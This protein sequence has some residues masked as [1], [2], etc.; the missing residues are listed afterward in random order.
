MLWRDLRL[1]VELDGKDA[2]TKPAQVA[3]DRE[4]DLVF[5]SSGYT[6]I[7]YT[8]AQVHFEPRAVAGDLRTQMS[9]LG[10]K[11]NGA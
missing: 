6:V 8:W 3:R 4:R 7:R 9:C 5:R 1:I 2:H 10:T 11:L